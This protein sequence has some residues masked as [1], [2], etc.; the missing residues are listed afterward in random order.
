VRQSVSHYQV[1]GVA[2]HA[3]H[4]EIRRAYRKL[5]REHHPDHNPDAPAEA[6]ARVAS[7][8]GAWEVLGDPEKRRAYD[9]AIGTTPRPGAAEPFLRDEPDDLFDDEFDDEPEVPVRQRPSDLLVVVPVFMLIAALATFVFGTMSESTMLRTVAILMAPVTAGAFIAAP[10]FM[11]LR[12][13]N[14]HR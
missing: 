5:V 7:I 6:R 14:R 11:M 10:L 3:T 12:G 13:R 8:I 9:W 2:P 4:E 1:L